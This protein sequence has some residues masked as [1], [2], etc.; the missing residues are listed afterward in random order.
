MAMT[1][2]K[3]QRASH[4]IE[5]DDTDFD[6]LFKEHWESI[7]LVTYR[8]VG[9]WDEAQDLA[10]ETFMQLYRK[11]PADDHNLGGWLY[12]VASRLGLNA[13]RS[14]KRR[15]YYEKEAGEA[16][17]TMNESPTPPQVEES[18]HKRERVRRAQR[19]VASISP[20]FAVALFRFFIR[21]NRCELETSPGFNWLFAGAR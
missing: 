9:D 18:A 1:L 21:R 5:E 11:P 3:R 4:L 12:R 16:F 19:N 17:L 10:L 7:C 13:L 14:R 8:L 6:A 20:D 2:S 15:Q